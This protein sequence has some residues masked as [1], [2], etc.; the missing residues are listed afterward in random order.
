MEG[1][2]ELWVAGVDWAGSGWLVVLWDGTAGWKAVLLCSFEEVLAL[3]PPPTAIAVDMPIGLPE[4]PMPGG[5]EADREA[6][7]LLGRPRASS[8]F[9]PPAERALRARNYWEARL[10]NQPAGLTKQAWGIFPGLRE[11]NRVLDPGLQKRIV[12]THPELGFFEAGARRPTLYS[13]RR[14][15]GLS[16]RRKLLGRVLGASWEHWSSEILGNGLLP[17]AREHDLL[18]ASMAAWTAAR[19]AAGEAV[20]V[21]KNPP[22]N[23]RGLRMEIW[24]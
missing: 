16:E 13:K 24:R 19:L 17:G 8:V 11:V 21:P 15:E 18:D 10:L 14:P 20:R 7:R 2:K 1:L 23:R 22:L 4:E 12:E 5:R 3:S 6:R 9:S